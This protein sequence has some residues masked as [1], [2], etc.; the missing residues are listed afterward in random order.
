MKTL[1]T[2][3]LEGV[4]LW[5]SDKVSK[6]HIVVDIARFNQYKGTLSSTTVEA[7]AHSLNPSILV[8]N[9][10]QHATEQVVFEDNNT[11][12]FRCRFDGVDCLCCIP[13]TSI[14]A[15]YDHNEPNNGMTFSYPMLGDETT[16]TDSTADEPKKEKKGFHLK[17]V[18]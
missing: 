10:G 17:L 16:P 5:L 3:L 4:Y 15:I 8:L 11:I 18:D 2:R 13:T 6:I 7:V 12:V 1:R 9:I 14:L